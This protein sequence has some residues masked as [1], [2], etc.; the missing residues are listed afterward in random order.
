MVRYFPWSRKNNGFKIRSVHL[1][2]AAINSDATS[3]NTSFR[4][5][6]EHVV[7]KFYNVY[8][9]RDDGLGLLAS[10]V[11]LLFIILS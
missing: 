8:D 1:L 11:D 7:D 2:R 10:I 5:A 6:I 3:R 4:D 9:P